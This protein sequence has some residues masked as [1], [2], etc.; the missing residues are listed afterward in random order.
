MATKKKTVETVT[1]TGVIDSEVSVEVNDNGE[2]IIDTPEI[3]EVELADQYK[4]I[5][6]IISKSIIEFSDN[7][8]MVSPETADSLRLQGI[9]K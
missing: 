1:S 5:T 3:V 4:G 7:K 8:A 2:E 9:I 6:S